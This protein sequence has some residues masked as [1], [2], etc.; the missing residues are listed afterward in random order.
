MGGCHDDGA[1]VAHVGLYESDLVEQ[2]G[3]GGSDFD[4]VDRAIVDSDTN[5][6]VKVHVKEVR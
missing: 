2:V 5:G 4:E 1:E 3:G 6:F